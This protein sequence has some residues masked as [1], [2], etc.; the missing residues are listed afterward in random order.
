M[1]DTVQ[2]TYAG[3][4]YHFP[5]LEGT[6]GEKAFDISKLRSE[7]GLITF[8]P[9]FLSTGSCKSE[10]TFLDGEK[11]ILLYRG[12]PIEQLAEHSNFLEVSY[13]LIHGHLPNK[14]E[15]EQFNFHITHHSMVH[16]SIKNL[17]DGFPKNPHPMA[18][19]STIVGSLATFYQEHQ[20]NVRDEREIEIS[21]H[22]LLA[23]LPTI[24]AYSFKK[25]IGQPLP[26]PKNSLN[27]TENFLH[28]MFS[29]PCEEYE[30]DPI[31]A[32]ALD[33]LLMLHADHEQNCST[34]TVRLVGSSMCNLFA[35]V[36]AGI[37]ALWGPL[38]GGANQAVIEMLQHIYDD[39]GQVEK[40]VGMA[41]TP[42]SKFRLMGFGH[43]VYKNFDPRSR[44]IKDL[45]YKVFERSHVNEP[46]L[47]IALKLEEIALKDEYFIE[48]KLYPNVDFYSGLIYKAL[49]IP[50]NMFPVM[51]AIGRL[52]GWIAQWKELQADEEFRIGRPRQVYMGRG[53]TDY[54]PLDERSE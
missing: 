9:G 24:A 28:M 41:K 18:V 32:R 4:T 37:Y 20:V 15:L 34:S 27:Y 46:L 19:C 2:I 31:T 16:E 38:H 49:G 10:I 12:V 36:S 48:H 7:T 8:D 53:K 13:L 43:R 39:G 6:C 11:G 51:F 5:I 3:K 45:A 29:N 1:D 33:V 26:Y 52:P 25:S 17:Y 22:R 42:D 14:G 44:I 47:E 50:V 30:L 54:I 35:S 21:I 23:K 40:F